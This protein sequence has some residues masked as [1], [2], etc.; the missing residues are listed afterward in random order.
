MPG[1][2]DL[3]RDRGPSVQESTANI[4]KVLDL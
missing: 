4:N 2:I 3:T 1:V